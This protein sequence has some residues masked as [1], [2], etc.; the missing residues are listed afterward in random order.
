MIRIRASKW[1]H[2]RVPI[3]KVTVWMVTSALWDAAIQRSVENRVAASGLTFCPKVYFLRHLVGH[4]LLIKSKCYIPKPIKICKCVFLHISYV[5]SSA[6]DCFIY[7]TWES[8]TELGI[9][10]IFNLTFF[11]Y[12][13]LSWLERG[14]TDL[15]VIKEKSAV[16]FSFH[17]QLHV[18]SAK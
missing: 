1:Q 2:C 15:W 3:V 16:C 4:W 13:I 8:C 12:L 5:H 11:F 7:E 17:S 9:G 10:H 18:V 6:G 14:S